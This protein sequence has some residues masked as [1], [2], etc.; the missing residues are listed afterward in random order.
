MSHQLITIVG[1]LGQ[2]PVLHTF[3]GGGCICNI[4]VA[5]TEKWKD[6]E[7]GE[8]KEWTEWHR[9]VLRGK[10]GELADKYLSKGDSVLIVGKNR[11]RMWEKDD[12]KRYTTEIQ[13]EQMK[14]M[15]TSKGGSDAKANAQNEQEA[16]QTPSQSQETKQAI[17]EDEPDDLP[18]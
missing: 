7:T 15:S 10:L 3:E 14:F 12:V 6:K 9:V 17:S 18:F 11:T 1:N 4:S 5:T 8:K 2:D 16:P 13:A